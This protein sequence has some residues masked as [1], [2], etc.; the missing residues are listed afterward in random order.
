MIILFH[1]T[2][3]KR[4]GSYCDIGVKALIAM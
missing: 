3:I 1:Q 4:I 2:I